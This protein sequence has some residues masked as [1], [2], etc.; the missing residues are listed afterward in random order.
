MLLHVTL[1]LTGL[2]LPVAR[3]W[4]A[5]Q[6]E[7]VPGSLGRLR[8][9]RVAGRCAAVS[10]W[11][12]ETWVLAGGR[13]SRRPH[14][15]LDRRCHRVRALA[16][17]LPQQVLA[18]RLPHLVEQCDDLADFVIDALLRLLVSFAGQLERADEPQLAQLAR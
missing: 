17:C 16:A 13:R 4:L 8:G 15:V 18:G 3:L 10:V 11:K 6:L 12:I 14:L 2:F 5:G 7:P 9:Q 1:I